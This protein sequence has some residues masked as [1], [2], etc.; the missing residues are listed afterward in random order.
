MSE[1][2]FQKHIPTDIYGF[3]KYVMTKDIETNDA[4]ILNLRVLGIFG[5]YENQPAASFPTISPGF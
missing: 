1:D 4:D 2:Y 3:S 5:K